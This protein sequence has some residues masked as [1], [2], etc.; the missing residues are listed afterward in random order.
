MVRESNIMGLCKSNWTLLIVIVSLLVF[1]KAEELRGTID[2]YQSQS[3]LPI[4]GQDQRVLRDYLSRPGSRLNQPLDEAVKSVLLRH[5]PSLYSR[6]CDRS[7]GRGDDIQPVKGSPEVRLVFVQGNKESGSAH[8][9]IAYG[10]SDQAKDSDRYAT[11]EQLAGLVL[12]KDGTKIFAVPLESGPD[13]CE[14]RV[15]IAPEKELKIGGKSIVGLRVVRSGGEGDPSSSRTCREEKIDFFLIDERDVRPAGSVM[16][17][18]EGTADD[19]HGARR[20]YEA[21]LV[22]RKDMKGNI[23][24]ILSPYV[25]KN[26]GKVSKKGMVRFN[27]DADKGEF[28]RE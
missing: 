27:W 19:P 8:A 11:D 3:D 17:A 26:D 5:R 21:A 16:R 7:V 2:V 1:M 14:G 24:G 4:L 12:D 15:R 25:I 23:T 10:C 28:V 6:G 13:G 18:Q 20:V 22:F 9:L